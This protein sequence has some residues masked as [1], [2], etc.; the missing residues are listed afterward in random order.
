[1]ASQKTKDL[2]RELTLTLR[3]GRERPVKATWPS[4]LWVSSNENSPVWDGSQT[5]DW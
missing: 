5:G 4:I 2:I 1:M 3:P